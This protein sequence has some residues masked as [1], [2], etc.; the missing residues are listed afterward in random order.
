MD[1]QEKV[2]TNDMKSGLKIYQ[3]TNPL[4]RILSLR[5]RSFILTSIIIQKICSDLQ[6]RYL[7]SHSAKGITFVVFTLQTFISDAKQKQKNKQKLEYQ[8]PCN[9]R[10]MASFFVWL[11]ALLYPSLTCFLLLFIYLNLNVKP[12]M[13]TLRTG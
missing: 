13:I 8:M 1:K 7:I 6:Y 4:C 11:Q 10:N 3:Q 12:P 5:S 2:I 9:E